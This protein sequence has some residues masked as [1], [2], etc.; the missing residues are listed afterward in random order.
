METVH[1]V[2]ESLEQFPA[3][4]AALKEPE[5]EPGVDIQQQALQPGF[6][7]EILHPKMIHADARERLPRLMTKAPP[8]ATDPTHSTAI[9]RRLMLARS[10]R[11]VS[12]E[13]DLC[14]I[15]NQQVWRPGGNLHVRVLFA[16]R[17]SP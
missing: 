7:T 14:Q 12:R 11:R 16:A 3:P 17:G 1:E 6:P 13:N 2:G 10:A 15:F 4:A 9:W 5:V 8:A